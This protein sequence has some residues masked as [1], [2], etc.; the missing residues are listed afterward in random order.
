MLSP[1]AASIPE[2][3]D[4]SYTGGGSGAQLMLELQR[5]ADFYAGSLD[6]GLRLL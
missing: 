3:N 5:E 1:G 4:R 2:S 6:V